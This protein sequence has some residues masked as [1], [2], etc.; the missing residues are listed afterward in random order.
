MKLW[1]MPGLT[2][3]CELTPI[4]T[5]TLSP[6]TYWRD[7]IVRIMLLNSIWS[8]SP[9]SGLVYCIYKFLRGLWNSRTKLADTEE[10]MILRYF[11]ALITCLRQ[12]HGRVLNLGVRYWAEKL[13]SYFPGIFSLS[14]W[15][16]QNFEGWCPIES[17]NES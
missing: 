11:P 8:L 9:G 7:W 16:K 5:S 2:I 3:L 12:G 14:T 10:A 1:N 4:H 13:L 6:H 17:Y 15:L